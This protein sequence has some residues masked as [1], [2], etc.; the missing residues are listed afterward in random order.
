MNPE[1]RASGISPRVVVLLIGTN[2][3]GRN[4]ALEIVGGNLGDRERDSQ[5]PAEYEDPAPRQ[6]FPGTKS[7]ARKIAR[8]SPR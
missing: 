2:N 3:A 1:W 8:K 5:S 6:F 4:T 7:P